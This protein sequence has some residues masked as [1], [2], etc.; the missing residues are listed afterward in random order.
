MIK[1]PTRTTRESSTLIDIIGTTQ[2][3]NILKSSVIK[4]SLS[5]HD[6]VGCVRKMHNIKFK[7]RTITCRN[8]KHFTA[9]SFKTD[10]GNLS[11][12]DYCSFTDINNAWSHWKNLFMSVVNKHVPLI[13][14]KVRG[15]ETPWINSK[16]KN[17][18][19]ERDHFLN[20]AR[21]SKS[22][23]DWSNYRRL[24][25]AVTREIRNAK[26]LYHRNLL[27]ENLDKP[28]KFWKAIKKLVPNE[29]TSVRNTT[30]QI[31]DDDK[32]TDNSYTTANAFCDFFCNLTKRMAAE[33]G[34]YAF[35]NVIT[36]QKSKNEFHFIPVLASSV[37]RHLNML[38]VCK[39][40]GIDGI[41]A[42]LLKV[43]ASEIYVSLTDIINLSLSTGNIP[44]E[45]KVA[46]VIPV[47]KSGPRDNPEN[48][49]PISVL[50][51][52]SKIL[53]RE[54]HIQLCKFI[55]KHNLLS[56]FQCGFR[57]NYSCETAVIYL[58]D[59]VRINAD[60]GLLTG[61][62]FID[63]KKAFDTVNHEYLLRKL[64]NFGLTD[65][66][67]NWFGDYLSGRT[68]RVSIDG[69]L[70]YSGEITAGV[71]QGS[72]LGPLLFVIFINDLPKVLTSSEILMYAD[73]TVIFCKSTEVSK[74]EQDLSRDLEKINEWMTDN[75]L[76]MHSGKTKVVLFGTHK[77][78]SLNDD[79]RIQLQ[80]KLVESVKYYKYLGVYLDR[81]LTFA[82]HIN[83]LK[84][85]AAKRLGALS[86]SRPF[87]T[88]HAA[89]KVYTAMVLPVFDYCDTVW[90]T[91]SDTQEDKL[92]K[93]QQR[94]V[95]IITM[96]QPYLL[97]MNWPSLNLRRKMHTAI[98]V[99]KC[100]NNNVPY[101]LQ[102]YISFTNPR[103]VTRNCESKCFIPKV[104]L[105]I[106]SNGFY[107]RGP[108]VYNSLPTYIRDEKLFSHF[109]THVYKYFSEY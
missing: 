72:I 90:D 10:I 84:V 85:K 36:L 37:L 64:F 76:Y 108:H 42:K 101:F 55:D 24:R 74:I 38:K 54:V 49:R 88:S 53:E 102:N 21:V 34:S 68:Q 20:K 103:R 11:F 48:Y 50:P 31:K 104:K 106:G 99:F 35:N 93:L 41:P 94:A 95:R 2:K 46:K 87:L 107:Y 8:Y 32:I 27:E 4:T 77:R 60:R 70:S 75:M 1:Q 25:N 39:S 56:P 96:N 28:S 98:L 3:Q 92:E 79:L 16:I 30:I 63:I 19:K 97:D 47:Y 57:K 65:T 23:L 59:S 40:T 18:M 91:L 45:W 52:L 14:K 82:E 29:N 66:E 71:P 109:R 100:L 62:A 105:V 69:V 51:A 6:M 15:R 61:A 13:N 9:D 22:E 67:I 44:D 12:P 89:V 7:P 80:G 78:L 73:D 43:V 17:I 86:R 83:R 5:D 33:F 58:T 26:G 81:G